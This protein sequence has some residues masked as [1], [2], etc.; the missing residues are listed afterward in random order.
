MILLLA[1]CAGTGVPRRHAL[2]PR[3]VEAL[4]SDD[5]AVRYEAAYVL[6][7]HGD[8]AHI[9]AIGE[10]AGDANAI[11]ARGALA[12][13]G[14]I[15]EGDSR[16]QAAALPHLMGALRH[17][18]ATVR[19]SAAFE[20]GNFQEC[21]GVD[22]SPLAATL[23]DESG[24]VQLAAAGA[25]AQLGIPPSDS[26][27]E[28]LFRSYAGGTG[29]RWLIPV[30]PA[31]RDPA[32]RDWLSPLLSSVD[33]RTRD[34]AEH[35]ARRLDAIAAGAPPSWQTSGMEK[36]L[37]SSTVNR[38]ARNELRRLPW[39]PVQRR[40]LL[41]AA[42]KARLVMFGEIHKE[43]GPLR[44]A[45]IELLRAIV[46]ERPAGVA[47]GFEPSVKQAQQLVLDAAEELGVPCISLE[48]NWEAGWMPVGSTAERDDQVAEAI[49]AWLATPGHR[50]FVV[51]GESHVTPGGYLVRQLETDPLIVLSMQAEIALPLGLAGDGLEI[52]GQ[53]WRL[54]DSGRVYVCGLKG[55]RPESPSSVLRNWLSRPSER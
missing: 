12:A 52:L 30:L 54:G 17:P 21:E 6:G 15:A 37:Q 47:V 27:L 55:L 1:A 4:R 20:L 7:A 3:L 11:V 43:D 22:W 10:L 38:R 8:G 14:R 28:R 39:H 50:M 45:Q 24:W 51:R 31:L 25:L 2:E 9:D 32:Q 23:W 5:P 48:K 19:Q 49:H 26:E 44:E 42:R 53:T 34:H 33:A 40:E 18:D 29:S 46:G 16:L 13:L 35:A 41:D 36:E